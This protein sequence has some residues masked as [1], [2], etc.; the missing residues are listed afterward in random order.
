MHQM[1]MTSAMRECIHTCLDCHSICMETVTHCL[2]LGGEHAEAS[3]IGLLLDCAQICQA[4]ADF[5]LRSSHRHIEMCGLCAQICR[6][7]AEECSRT[8]GGDETMRRCAETCSR[9]ADSCRRMT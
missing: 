2:T 9:C 5:M 8:A 7:C 3:H 6:A 4:S 1:T